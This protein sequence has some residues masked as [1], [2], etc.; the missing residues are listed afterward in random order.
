MKLKYAMIL[1]AM[2]LLAPAIVSAADFSITS[3]PQLTGKINEQYN[4][5][6][7]VSNPENYALSYSVD[8]PSGMSISNSGVVT[9]TPSSG[10]I[11][12]V[13]IVVSNTT[14]NVTQS[15][16]VQV[17]GDPS[18]ITASAVELGSSTQRRGE[19]V[20]TTYEI[21]NTG[22][23]D[24]T[25]LEAE[26][27]NVGTAYD[28]QISLP[29]T[30]IPAKNSILASVTAQVPMTQDSG[31]NRIGQIVLNG[32]SNNV[33]NTQTRDVFLETQ[34][35]LVIENIEVTVGGRR[36]RMDS[37]GTI[38]R[39]AQLGDRIEIQLRIRNDFDNIELED[40]EAEL[41]S[42]DID[43]ADGQLQTLRRLRA[44]RTSTDLR[45]D[46]ILDD[47]RLELEDAPFELELVVFGIDENNARHGETWILELDIERQTRDVRLSR[48]TLTPTLVTCENTF[49]TVSTDIRNIGI[50]DL[51][52]AM[53]QVNIPSLN[54]QE[55][56]RNLDLW[57]GDS[58]R[59]NFNLNIPRDARP[60]QY[61]VEVYAHPT[62]TVGDWT[63]SEV[64]TLQVGNCP[65]DTTEPTQP[66]EP[67]NGIIVQPVDNQTP[68]VVGTP[69]TQPTTSGFQDQQLYI[70]LLGAI[71]VILAI[72]LIILLIKIL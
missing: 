46:F 68:I 18:Q 21:T 52:N 32:Q 29:S 2:L 8:G 38:R 43:D 33:V 4:Y 44:G 61:T 34:N 1:T 50:R 65:T 35:M 28:I 63:D 25:N 56:R 57:V 41:F 31:R 9:W 47:D 67:S 10:G 69:V 7:I 6:V 3:S 54:I 5:E 42:L 22:S 36:E 71:V 55:F 58:S 23:W 60:G 53:V 70:I 26:F 13:E 49:F 12:D 51:S 48:T 45:F 39:E 20:T 27:V 15:F 62:V 24:I 30:T 19:L 14:D 11:F 17:T 40:I 37:P 59:V 16:Q 72:L 66:S 64:L